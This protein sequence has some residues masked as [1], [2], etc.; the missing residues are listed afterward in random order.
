M[1]DAKKCDRCGEYYAPSNKS[2]IVQE[3]NASGI[4]MTRNGGDVCQTCAAKFEK[5]W[6]KKRKEGGDDR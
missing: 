3:Y 2:K 5:W 6:R 4:G 1:T